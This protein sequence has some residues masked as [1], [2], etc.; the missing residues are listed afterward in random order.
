M[1]LFIFVKK[2]LFVF[3]HLLGKVVLPLLN[4]MIFCYLDSI[5]YFVMDHYNFVTKAMFLIEP[6]YLVQLDML[7]CWTFLIIRWLYDFIHNS[8]APFA[9]KNIEHPSISPFWF[10][11]TFIWFVDHNFLGAYAFNFIFSSTLSN[12]LPLVK[13]KHLDYFWQHVPSHFK[14]LS[15]S[16]FVSLG[17]VAC[18]TIEL[19]SY[20]FIL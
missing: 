6:V 3:D 9:M 4:S 10:F 17:F 13:L 1:N 15:Y 5:S 16:F 11:L 14:L 7:L 20:I 8:C 12:Y 2:D 19:Y 18:Y